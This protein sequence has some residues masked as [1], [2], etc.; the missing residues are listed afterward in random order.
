MFGSVTTITFLLGFDG[1]EWWLVELLED[2]IF[3]KDHEVCIVL[4][5][6][7]SFT[8]FCT[9]FLLLMS[10]VDRLQNVPKKQR[11]IPKKKKT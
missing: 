1:F 7:S 11:K 9:V 10:N 8:T 5:H 6:F 4:L 3:L 2:R